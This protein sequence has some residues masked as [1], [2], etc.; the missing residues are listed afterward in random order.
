MNV[1]CEDGITALMKAACA[2]FP[3]LHVMFF[4][5]KRPVIV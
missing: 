4:F 2:T 1:T 5:K 3:C